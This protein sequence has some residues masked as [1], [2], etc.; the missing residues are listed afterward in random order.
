VRELHQAR[1]LLILSIDTSG[2]EGSLALLRG[3]A[4]SAQVLELVPLAGRQYSAEL[5]PLLAAALERQ[6]ISKQDIEAY[7]VVTGPGSFTG[8][9]VGI[10]TVKGLAEIF[11]RPI[12]A[13][14]MLEAIALTTMQV[15]KVIAALDAGRREVYVGEYE[16]S[17]Q[18]AR[19][20]SEML[21]SLD[22][23]GKRLDAN[24]SAQLI[25]SELHIAEAARFH[26][27]VKQVERPQAD[28]IGRIGL[29]KIP[30]GETVAPEVLEANYIRRSDA[31]IFGKP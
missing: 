8:L 13:V 16:V 30:A 14:S 1:I 17:T 15:G 2:R 11:G 26:T 7:A 23:F 9:R 19:C 25:T 21:L 12:A 18:G 29:K 10:A 4:E 22:E 28:E 31:E 27:Q 6:K 5:I 20:A 3:S 24:P